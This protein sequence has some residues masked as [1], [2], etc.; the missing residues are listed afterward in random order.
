MSCC[1]ICGGDISFYFKKSYVASPYGK[2][3]QDWGDIDIFAVKNVVLLSPYSL[4]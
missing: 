2:L 3:M 4:S 1:E